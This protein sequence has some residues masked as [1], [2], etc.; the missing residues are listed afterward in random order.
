MLYTHIHI[1]IYTYTQSIS[2]I[3]LSPSTLSLL[4]SS[5][6][7]SLPPSFSLCFCFWTSSLENSVDHSR[8][9][10]SLSAYV[11]LRGSNQAT[12]P[13]Q[14]RHGA[15]LAFVTECK[16]HHFI[17][18]LTIVKMHCCSHFTEA[19]IAPKWTLY[20]KLHSALVVTDVKPISKAHVLSSNPLQS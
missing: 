15:Q 1:C 16:L 2:H 4:P 8:L 19:N 20:L 10:P 5:P 7:L 17:V 6:I 3:F 12:T 18:P 9:F 13:Y 14:T 11:N